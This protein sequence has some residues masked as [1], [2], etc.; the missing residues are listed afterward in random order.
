MWVA[1]RRKNREGAVAAPG[2]GAVGNRLS[3]G[4]CMEV[5]RMTVDRH[6]AHKG[7]GHW[8]WQVVKVVVPQSLFFRKQ[9]KWRFFFDFEKFELFHS[10]SSFVWSLKIALD[11]TSAALFECG[12]RTAGY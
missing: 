3:A 11:Q 1:R 8:G 2:G 6:L 7:V 5:G 10:S 4:P 12:T 9:Q